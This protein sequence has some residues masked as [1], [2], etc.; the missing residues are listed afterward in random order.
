MIL[1]LAILSVAAC[2]LVAL[3]GY[4]AFIAIRGMRRY[5]R[6]NRPMATRVTRSR[7][8]DS[9]PNDQRDWQA[10]FDRIMGNK[11]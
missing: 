6:D 10:G 11:R 4:L 9:K 3:V 8:E 2:A 7:W 5:Y 1:Y